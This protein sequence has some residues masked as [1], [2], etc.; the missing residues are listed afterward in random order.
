MISM[1][2]R[3][4]F[5]E[6]NLGWQTIHIYLFSQY[7]NLQYYIHMRAAIKMTKSVIKS[8]QM[9]NFK[10]IMLF[11]KILQE[12]ISKC[13]CP[14][15]WSSGCVP[16]RVETAVSYVW[17][18]Q[19]SRYLQLGLTW[20]RSRSTLGIQVCFYLVYLLTSQWVSVLSSP[21]PI[22]YKGP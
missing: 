4:F 17:H 2:T 8:L 1:K 22:P 18:S 13:W 14:Y 16:H 6:L 12:V 3:G 9:C 21:L 11:N 5:P 7:I 15:V 10:N 20:W 19:K